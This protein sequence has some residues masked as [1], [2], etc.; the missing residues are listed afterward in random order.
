MLVSITGPGSA[1][2]RARS[3]GT[4]QTNVKGC[5]W[6]I[7]PGITADLPTGAPG[8]TAELFTAMT[9]LIFTV[10]LSSGGFSC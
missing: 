3:G 5:V 10:V 8:G 6:L 2:G 1:V 7:C 9:R 4:E